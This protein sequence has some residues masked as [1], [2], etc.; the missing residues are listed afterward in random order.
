MVIGR[1]V[2]VIEDTHRE[3]TLCESKE[4]RRFVVSVFYPAKNDHQSEHE[5]VYLDLFSPQVEAAENIFFQ[6]GC[7]RRVF[8]KTWQLI[9]I[10]MH[11]SQMRRTT[12][13]LLFIP[14]VSG[15]TGICIS[16]TLVNSYLR[17]IWS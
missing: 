7:K 10:M 2:R 15:S 9:V 11:L 13:P 16:F 1:I 3:E 5:P 4:N 17:V 12:F 6:H 14:L 8:K